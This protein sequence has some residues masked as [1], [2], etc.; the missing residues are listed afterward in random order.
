MQT[1]LSHQPLLMYKIFR[2]DHQYQAP[3]KATRFFQPLSDETRLLILQCLQ[4]GEQRVCDL[5]DAFKTCQSRLSFHL[6]VVKDAAL[7]KDRP[8]GRWIYYSLNHAGLEELTSSLA[9]SRKRR[10]ARLLQYC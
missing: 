9:N 3:E 10:T 1:R 8:E 5:T 4:T 2:G 6:K 7:V